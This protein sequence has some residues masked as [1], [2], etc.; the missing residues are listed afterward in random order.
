MKLKFTGESLKKPAFYVLCSF[1]VI[2]I[3]SLTVFRNPGGL[4]PS[5]PDNGG[6]T[7]PDGF[8]AVVVVDSLG[9]ARHLAVN[10]N[11]DIYVKLILSSILVIIKMWAVWL[12]ECVFTRDTFITVLHWPFTETN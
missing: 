2:S 8:E 9:P 12:M 10:N 3:L 7:F 1:F 11:G 4:P 5:D 6:L